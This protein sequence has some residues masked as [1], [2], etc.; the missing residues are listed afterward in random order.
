MGV[1]YQ[2][3]KV[4]VTGGSGFIGSNFIRYLH[5]QEP[6]T[7]IVN[8]DN[9]K[10][11]A[12]QHGSDVSETGEKIQGN[13][14]SPWLFNI[15]GDIA[16]SACV[17]PIISEV[18]AVINFAAQTH[19]VRS[20]MNAR[21]FIHSNIEGVNNLLELS[22]KHGLKRFIHISTDEVYGSC[23][24]GSFTETSP[25]CPN[26][27]YSATK[28]AGDLLIR[29]YMV[30]YK[31]PAVILRPSNNFGPFQFPEKVLPVFIL[32]AME[33]KPLPLYGDGSNIREWLFVEDTCA[34]VYTALNN[35]KAGE[36]FNV[37]GGHEL[38]N[39]ELARMVLDAM[40]KPNDRIQHVKDR[41]GHDW[42]YSLDTK[43]IMDELGWKPS[44]NFKENLAKTIQWYQDHRDW[45]TDRT[46]IAESFRK[47]YRQ[48][49]GVYTAL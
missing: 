17:Q 9:W 37:G 48:Q 27:P 38:A 12:S 25:L 18:D 22:L 8:L 41:P 11:Y 4:L 42:R 44:G 30:T 19:V 29:S 26:N 5:A 13:E 2:P 34:A 28:A 20:I 10:T 24:T 23:K 3:M 40:G 33:D 1:F 14:Q 47:A 36:I 45:C 32:N 39:S 6:T 35:F 43:K 46:A 7:K 16:D 15:D 49:Y 31:F 21:D